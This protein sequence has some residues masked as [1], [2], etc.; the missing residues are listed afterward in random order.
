MCLMP[1]ALPLGLTALPGV[2]WTLKSG[3][4]DALDGAALRIRPDDDAAGT[5]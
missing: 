1:L 4:Y 5:Q 2:L 3:Q